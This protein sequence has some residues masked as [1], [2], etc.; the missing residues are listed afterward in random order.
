MRAHP[1]PVIRGGCDQKGFIS[2]RAKGRCVRHHRR[3]GTRLTAQQVNWRMVP[4]GTAAMKKKMLFARRDVCPQD[5]TA[6]R[7]RA[8][9]QLTQ[10]IADMAAPWL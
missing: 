4:G 5:T 9:R 2:I 8:S 1:L 3:M 6:A 7:K 10:R